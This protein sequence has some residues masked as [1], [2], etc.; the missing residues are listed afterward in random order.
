MLKGLRLRIEDQR[1]FDRRNQRF[2]GERRTQS[3][4]TCHETAEMEHT[5]AVV[6][7]NLRLLSPF[8]GA[9]TRLAS[10]CGADS[11]G[12]VCFSAR[13]RAGA[14]CCVSNWNKDPGKD[15]EEFLPG[16]GA[17]RRSISTLPDT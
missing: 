16:L 11:T 7:E 4:A 5:S 17:R 13:V 12:R 1:G 14:N 8:P 6:K 9:F 15:A 10:E 3:P 2:L